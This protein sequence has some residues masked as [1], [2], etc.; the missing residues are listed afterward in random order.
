V[1]KAQ[2]RGLIRPSGTFSKREGKRN[3]VLLYKSATPPQP[4]RYSSAGFKIIKPLFQP[5]CFL[6]RVFLF[7]LF[8]I[9]GDCAAVAGLAERWRVSALLFGGGACFASVG[10]EAAALYWHFICFLGGI[11][12]EYDETLIHDTGADYRQYWF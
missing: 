9:F 2:S 7:H 8:N 4:N 12:I 1:D 3:E 6:A 10:G 11:N 5:D